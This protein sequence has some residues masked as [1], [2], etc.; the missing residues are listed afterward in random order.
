M[1]EATG[2]IDRVV[3]TTAGV[4]GSAPS[5]VLPSGPTKASPSRAPATGWRRALRHKSFAVGGT[6]VLLLILVAALSFVW[7]P[8]SA[9][10]IDVPN[11]LHAPDAKNRLGPD[12][13]GRDV[14]SL[15][16]VG[17]RNS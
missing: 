1:P 10:E 17:A 7:T 8:H 3:A 14:V 5:T 4:V 12:S 15:L 11:R 13:L 6:L 2:G 9:T 16:I